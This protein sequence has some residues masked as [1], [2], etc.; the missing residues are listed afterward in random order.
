MKLI[1]IQQNTSIPFLCNSVCSTYPSPSFLFGPLSGL[2]L[3]VELATADHIPN[4]NNQSI[5]LKHYPTRVIIRTVDTSL[6]LPLLAPPHRQLQLQP[7]TTLGFGSARLGRR[8]LGRLNSTTMLTQTR[9]PIQLTPRVSRGLRSDRLGFRRERLRLGAGSFKAATI[10]HLMKR[11][12]L[13]F[14][15]HVADVAGFKEGAGGVR[16]ELGDGVAT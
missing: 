1:Y 3:Y 11:G 4:Q 7:L 9:R 12:V 16:G 2:H 10:S 8:N 15:I 6:P 14:V 13:L 5:T